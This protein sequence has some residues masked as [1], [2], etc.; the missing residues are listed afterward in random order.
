MS[1]VIIDGERYAL[2]FGETI[3]GGTGPGAL[4]ARELAA[5]EPFVAIDYPVDGPTT[6]RRVGD[7]AVMLNGAPLGTA[8]HALKHGDRFETAGLSVAYG[9][10]RRA[11]RTSHVSA[12]KRPDADV[13]IQGSQAVPTACTGG[14]VTRLSDRAVFPVSGLGLTFGRDPSSDI[15]LSSEGVSRA[16]ATI[17]PGLLGYTLKDTS[18]NGVEVNGARVEGSHL[19]GQGDVMRL[20]QEEFRFDADEPSFEPDARLADGSIDAST[21]LVAATPRAK[22]ARLLASLEVI[23][24]G[25]RKGERYRIERPTVQM[26]RGEHNEI[27][28][29]D[30][31]VSTSHASFVQR[32]GNWVI[33]DLGSRNG[34][35][36]DGEIVREQRELPR[37]CEVRLGAL[38]MLFR[39]IDSGSS[40]PNSTI[41]VVRVDPK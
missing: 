6:A 20:G 1:F 25:P 26:G 3:L 4:D 24:E 36:V 28:V 22:P 27:R 15:V 12:V 7:A 33:I 37:V 21:T 14:R 35:F 23:S 18:V 32:A 31:T 5:A 9:D 30:D 13:G 16:H 11:H 8:P 41:N 38:T 17:A 10:V 2:D 39:A 34:T 19:L 29:D 40:R